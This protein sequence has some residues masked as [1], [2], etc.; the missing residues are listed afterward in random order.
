M[1]NG[2]KLG[3]IP[4]TSGVPQES[5]L[6]PLLFT[7][8][9]NDIPSVVSSP[10]F[11][12]ADDMKIFHFVRS[13]D[14]HATL[15]N[16]LNILHKWSVRWQLKFNISKCK[17]ADFGPVH[18]FGSYYLNGIKIDN[19]ESQ[20]HLGILFDH[21]LIISSIYTPL[22]LLGLIRKSFDYLNPDMLVKL[23]VTVVR[24]I[25]EYCNS[26]WGPL[27]IKGK[28]KRFNVELQ[29]YYHQLETDLMGRDS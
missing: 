29:D 20:K 23:F 24:P 16:D 25:L 13:S 10:T 11:M 14:D 4:V 6:G 18:Q 2:Q 1:L 8:F 27:F 21:Q 15:Q 19:V 7:I 5:V 28:S 9:V 12:F 26:V 3:L 17:H 22:M